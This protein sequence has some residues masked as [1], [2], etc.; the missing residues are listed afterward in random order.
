[1]IIHEEKKKT[2]R[3]LKQIILNRKCKKKR[4]WVLAQVEKNKIWIICAGGNSQQLPPR[5]AA[6]SFPRDATP[7]PA[8]LRGHSAPASWCCFPC[9]RALSVRSLCALEEFH[10]TL[11]FYLGTEAAQLPVSQAAWGS[12]PVFP[13]FS[14]TTDDKKR[15]KSKHFIPMDS[16]ILLNFIE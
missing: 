9:A 14:F 16:T 15:H 10:G 12:N 11:G 1:M 4:I 5:A 13:G 6:W 8:R 3:Q 2:L 7:A